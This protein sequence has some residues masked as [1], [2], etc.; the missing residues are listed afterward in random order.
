MDCE[1][2]V[3]RLDKSCILHAVAILF[4]VDEHFEVIILLYPNSLMFFLINS[5]MIDTLCRSN[6]SDRMAFDIEMTRKTAI[7]RVLVREVSFAAA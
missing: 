5:D 4:C 3:N 1:L 7:C 6:R 2:E